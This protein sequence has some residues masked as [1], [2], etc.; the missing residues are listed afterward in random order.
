MVAH[1][2]STT[3]ILFVLILFIASAAE[4]SFGQTIVYPAD[5]SLQ[6]L[7]AAKE[8]RRYIYL[9]TGQ[10]LPLK[11]NNSIPE[12]G[13]IILVADESNFNGKYQ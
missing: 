2:K 11:K 13:D 5:G 10:K 1:Q 8:V 7:I 12:K 6:E 4:L 9:M 3:P